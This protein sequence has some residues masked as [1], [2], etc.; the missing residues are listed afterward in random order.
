MD[1]EGNERIG[2]LA[3]MRKDKELLLTIKKRKIQYLG[4]VLRGEKYEMLRV[5]L[6]GK[7]SGKRSIGRRQNSWMKDLRRWCACSTTELFRK[8]VSKVQLALWIA[9]FQSGNGD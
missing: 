8:A 6:Q 7:I 9:N 1:Q 2:V 3:R 4:H 5:I